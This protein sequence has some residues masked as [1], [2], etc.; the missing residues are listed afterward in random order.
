[1]AVNNLLDKDFTE[2]T[3][4]GDITGYKYLS[5]GSSMAGTYIPGRN[6]WLSISYDF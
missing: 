5:L 3:V 1:M 2:N 4:F 6:Y